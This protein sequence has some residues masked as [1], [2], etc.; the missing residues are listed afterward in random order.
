MDDILFGIP[1]TEKL[2][3]AY[4]GLKSWVS[5]GHSYIK[6]VSPGGEEFTV[7]L[8]KH[9][10]SNFKEKRTRPNFKHGTLSEVVRNSISNKPLLLYLSGDDHLSKMFEV[11]IL[12]VPEIVSLMVRLSKFLVNNHFY[13][14]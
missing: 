12:T 1:V 13:L 14:E 2:K 9:I 3:N 7:R 5:K 6:G 10:L 8:D 4:K 11:E